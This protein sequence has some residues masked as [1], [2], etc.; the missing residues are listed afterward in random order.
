MRKLLWNPFYGQNE[1][2]LL[3]AGVLLTLF[4]L[5][6]SVCTGIVQDG[7]LDLHFADV[8]VWQHTL[9]L[10]VNILVLTASCFAVGK[11]IHPKSR[12]IDMLCVSLVSR[13]PLYL[14]IWMLYLLPMDAAV[15]KLSTLEAGTLPQLSALDWLALMATSI[16]S[17]VFLAWHLVLHFQGFRVAVNAK[18]RVH[19]VY[20]LLAV[21]LAEILSK[22]LIYL[23]I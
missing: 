5:F 10:G 8:A 13:A 20:W 12:L 15:E 11:L 3:L 4:G 6:S 22:V 19:Y 14:S 1:R 17:L 2:R 7:V 23:F 21:L 18:R 16:G 9:A